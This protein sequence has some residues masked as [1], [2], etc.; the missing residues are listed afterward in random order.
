MQMS[1]VVLREFSVHVQM[2][3]YFRPGSFA[4]LVSACKVPIVPTRLLNV[5][6]YFKKY[7][8]GL[9]AGTYFA[10]RRLDA[11]VM[12]I[13]QDIVGIWN[14]R[15]EDEV[16]FLS[17]F[18]R[19]LVSSIFDRSRFCAVRLLRMLSSCLCKIWPMPMGR[20]QGLIR[21]LYFYSAP[22]IVAHVRL[23][24]KNLECIKPALDVATPL[25]GPL[26]LVVASVGL[27]VMFAKWLSDM[28]HSKYYTL[29]LAVYFNTLSNSPGVRRCLM[30][31]S[32]TSPLCSR[33]CS[34]SK[35]LSLDYHPSVKMILLRPSGCIR[36]L[37]SISKFIDR[38]ADTL[39]T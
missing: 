37:Q 25:S 7:W 28:Y 3:L 32:S 36:D 18:A 38:S 17:S 33:S 10:D 8:R 27:S 26:A 16:S 5:L 19:F 21:I 23:R 39:I 12:V 1:R 9:A 4:F 29:P 2:F 30:G 34:S 13:H 6:T 15:D 20:V 35:L 31:I 24:T 14:F 22:I 11:C